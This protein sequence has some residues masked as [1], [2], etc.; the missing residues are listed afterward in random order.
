VTPSATPRVR[1]RRPSPDDEAR[2]LAAAARSRA[3]HRAWV[4]P[5]RTAE[6]FARWLSRGATPREASWLAIPGEC[7]DIAGVFTLSEIVRG[8]LQSAYLGFYAFRPW[9]GRG[10]MTAAL[11]LVAR[12]A[13]VGLGLH[14][15]EANIQPGN[16]RSIAL[17]TRCAFRREGLS[18]RYL[19]IGGRWRDHERWALL[20]EDWRRAR[21]EGRARPPAAVAR[22]PPPAATYARI[23][24]V[25]R[26]IPRG[27]VA[28]YGQ[29]AELAKLDG[30]ARQV[31]Y[32]LHALPSGAAVPWHRVLNARGAVSLRAGD[33]GE[34]IQRALLEREGVRF[35]RDARIDLERYRWRPRGAEGKGPW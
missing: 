27:R 23:Y 13:F 32:A 8:P 18:R 22:R 35:G 14:R 1:L 29:V 28:T 31:G 33:G 4:H 16:R 34:V 11:G 30:H 10:I 26:R 20:A 15:M 2:F 3:L 24:A 19:K 6:S 17:V 25:V 12:E 9:A 5:P 7:E 21:R